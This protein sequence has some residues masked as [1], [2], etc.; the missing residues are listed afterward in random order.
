MRFTFSRL[1]IADQ[2]LFA[3]ADGKRLVL[4]PKPLAALAGVC[5]KFAAASQ[6]ALSIVLDPAA[7]GH[8]AAAQ[9]CLRR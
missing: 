1:L 9:R 6:G 2:A 7:F 4:S 3:W 8:G 5:G